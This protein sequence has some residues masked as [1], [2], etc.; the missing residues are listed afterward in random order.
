MSQTIRAPILILHAHNDP[1]I[2]LS[3]SRTLTDHLL[4]PLLTP[5]ADSEATELMAAE[6]GK[7]RDDLVRK[8]KAGGWGVVSRFERQEGFGPVIWA[9]VRSSSSVIL[10]RRKARLVDLDVPV[11][12]ALKGAHNEIGTHEYSIELGESRV[13]GFLV[14]LSAV[15]FT[16][17]SIALLGVIGRQCGGC[18]SRGACDS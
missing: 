10:F 11:D 15:A 7:G 16:L 12:Q 4:A 3:H 8:Y 17:N 18:C 2:P 14:R 6:N 9:E 13:L 1:V 5:A